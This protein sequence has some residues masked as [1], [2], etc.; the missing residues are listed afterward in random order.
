MWR[1]AWLLLLFATTQTTQ[2]DPSR[3][4]ISFMI[5]SCAR[6][7]LQSRPYSTDKTHKRTLRPSLF[8]YLAIK[9]PH[10]ALTANDAPEEVSVVCIWC[11]VGVIDMQESAQHFIDNEVSRHVQLR[12]SRCYR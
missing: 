6:P 10:N 12:Y 4:G 9:L 3:L 7:R 2:H 8:L 11:L 5:G 1:G